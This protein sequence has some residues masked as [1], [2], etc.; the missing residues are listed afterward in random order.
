[1]LDHEQRYW[2]KT[3]EEYGVRL[4]ER[5]LAIAVAAATLLGASTRDIAMQTLARLPGL[6]D[7][8]EDRLFAVDGWLRDLYPATG[9]HWG[10]LEP[11]RLFDHHIGA[12]FADDPNLI[13]LLLSEATEYQAARALTALRRAGAHQF[14]L[15][16]KVR[17]VLTRRRSRLER[18]A[19]TLTRMA[20]EPSLSL[21]TALDV[22]YDTIGVDDRQVAWEQWLQAPREAG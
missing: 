9:D 10:T 12:L 7:Q 15:A 11:D 4:H 6:R 14:Q 16:L 1:M 18:V 13:D 22:V 19:V 21:A 17:E 5:T 20:S 2:Q 8:P 3:A